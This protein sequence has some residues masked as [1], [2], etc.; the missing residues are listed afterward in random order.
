MKV[1]P[2]RTMMISMKLTGSLI[3]VVLVI[4]LMVNW[5]VVADTV[6]P[7]SR[8][9]TMN[10]LSTLLGPKVHD[11]DHACTHTGRQIGCVRLWQT[12]TAI[13]ALNHPSVWNTPKSVLIDRRQTTRGYG[14][15]HTY[16]PGL[17]G[18]LHD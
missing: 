4:V 7:V 2:V 13:L 10:I 15:K 8:S 9:L 6:I 11:L 16:H 1:V 5:A 3:M 18:H 17:S 12:L 14:E